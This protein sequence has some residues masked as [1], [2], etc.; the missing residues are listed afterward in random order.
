M[1][2]AARRLQRSVPTTSVYPAITVGASPVGSY[3]EPLPGS[4]VLFVSPSGSDGNSGT[5]ASPLKTVTAAVS[6]ISASG[7]TI[8]LRAGTYHEQ[9][10]IGNSV[11]PLAIR[12]YPGEAVW[13]D[14]SE[15]FAATWTNNGNG[16]WTAPYTLTFDRALGMGAVPSIYSGNAARV[17]I[18]QVW[19]NDVAL[20]PMADNTTPGAGQFSVNQTAHTVTVG[21]NPAG[22]AIRVA[23][24]NYAIVRYNNLN[25]SLDLRGVGIRRYSPYWLEWLFSAVR[26]SPDSVMEQVTI[27]ESGGGAIAAYGAS[28]I[29][30]C[31]V[32]DTYYTG[33]G[34]GYTSL[35]AAGKSLFEKNIVRRVNRWGYWDP[36]PGTA[37][38][39]FFGHC[40]GTIVRHN[41]FEDMPNCAAIWFDTSCTRLQIVNNTVIGTSHLGDSY[42]GKQGIELELSDGGYYSGV[43]YYSYVV[44]NRIDD[45]RF[46][47][48]QLFDSGYIKAWNNKIYSGSSFYLW[49]DNRQNTGSDAASGNPTIAPWHCINNEIC[50]ND[51]Q[52]PTAYGPRQII[53]YS[54]TDAAVMYKGGDMF[55]II[56][57]NWFKPQ[58]V[59]NVVTLGNTSG[60]FSGTTTLAGLATLPASVGGPFGTERISDNYLQSVA[61]TGG[62]IP[63]PADVATVYGVPTGTRAI[64]PVLP[65]LE[66]M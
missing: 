14:G 46:A 9:V 13:F 44:G 15:P 62:G 45:F 41:Y 36:E 27:Q 22:K 18:D 1:S 25:T 19:F 26:L 51:T 61:P 12:N 37:G 64:G 4:N 17:V 50:N 59:G 3:S 24:L 66:L 33:V 11:P 57:G 38:L 34:G 2:I 52:C 47:G 16:T 28:T 5:Q 40:D 58:T 31:T 56:K 54:N 60:G 55:S 39:K 42:R 53:A 65:Q 32:Q 6:K 29:R 23:T 21:S 49:Q 10:T 8:V 30:N 7:W 48:I 35:G 63:I 20:Q 43:Q